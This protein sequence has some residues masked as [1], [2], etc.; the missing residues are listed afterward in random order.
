LRRIR[1]FHHQQVPWLPRPRKSLDMFRQQWIEVTGYPGGGTALQP[2]LDF[3]ER[4]Y[5]RSG[6]QKQSLTVTW[7]LLSASGSGI[8]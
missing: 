1:Y 3:V 5:F 7:L 4:D 8:S 6:I 2:L